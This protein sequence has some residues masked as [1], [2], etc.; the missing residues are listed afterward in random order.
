MVLRARV[1]NKPKAFFS[2]IK[3]KREFWTR[4]TSNMGDF[5]KIF[6]TS[7]PLKIFT[8]SSILGVWKDPETVSGSVYVFLEIIDY[9][10]L[11]FICSY[12]FDLINVDVARKCR[13]HMVLICAFCFLMSALKI[14]PKRVYFSQKTKD[15]IILDTTSLK[16]GTKRINRK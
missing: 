15:N 10:W 6:D 1:S 4:H 12:C 14:W 8:G 5:V 16:S 11:T 3:V 7:N 9:S 13:V 2:F